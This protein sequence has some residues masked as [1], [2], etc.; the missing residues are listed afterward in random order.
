MIARIT[1][2]DIQIA[3]RLA[4]ARKQAGLSQEKLG[5][6]IGVAF[7]QI[8]KYEKGTNRI[9]AGRLIAFAKIFNISLNWF[10]ED[11]SDD[12]IISKNT[13][14]ITAML[15]APYGVEL[16]HNYLAIYL[17][18]DKKVIVKVAEALAE[19]IK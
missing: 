4:I 10:Y 12:V 6:K 9:S 14:I 15:N 5:E 11:T 7:Q 3:K 18:S 17:N 13:D 8:Q 19:R 2:Y 16:A 1:E